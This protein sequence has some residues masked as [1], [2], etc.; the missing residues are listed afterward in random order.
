MTYIVKEILYAHLSRINQHDDRHKGIS[1]SLDFYS[2][3]MHE[4]AANQLQG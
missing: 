1:P 3:K 4:E 2:H